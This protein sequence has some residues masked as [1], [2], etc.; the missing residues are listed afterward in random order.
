MTR[1]P[2]KG[3]TVSMIVQSIAIIFVISVMAA[4]Y[5]RAGKVLLAALALPLLCLP[6]SHLLSIALWGGYSLLAYVVMLP[7]G[8]LAGMAG[9][10]L[11]SRKITERSGRIAYISLCSVF[12]LALMYAYLR[13]LL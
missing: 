5:L 3:T 11:F 9:Y 4:M 12:S 7:T 6:L 2:A 10:V 8:L 1:C 13:F